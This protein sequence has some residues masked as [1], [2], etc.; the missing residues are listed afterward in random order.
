MEPEAKQNDANE[1]AAVIEPAAAIPHNSDIST[2]SSSV[3]TGIFA[4]CF[5]GTSFVSDTALLT[6]TTLPVC[7]DD[8]L[9]VAEALSPIDEVFSRDAAGSS[10]LLD[11]SVVPQQFQEAS[12][13]CTSN[14][15][16]HAG[17]GTVGHQYSDIQ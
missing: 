6:S 12:L 15:Q 3:Q 9:P 5:S 13:L 7:S 16:Q 1:I 17:T 8:A 4:P 10:A 2:T 14:V 11:A